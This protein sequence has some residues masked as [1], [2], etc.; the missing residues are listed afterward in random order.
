MDWNGTR[1]RTRAHP[2]P[3]AP[4]ADLRAGRGHPAGR[5][6]RLP[7]APAGGGPGGRDRRHP[8]RGGAAP[9]RSAYRS[10]K[11]AH[12]PWVRP[13]TADLTFLAE[14]ADTGRLTVEVAHAL[15]WDEAA[16]AW[17]LSASGR[18]RGKIV[19]TV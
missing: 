2:R 8:L 5:P 1:V 13:G 9:A 4:L 7:V 17:E 11:G 14:P 6:R 10:A 3:Q 18:T 15:P 19:L 16:R 12:Q